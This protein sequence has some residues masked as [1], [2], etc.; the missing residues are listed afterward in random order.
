MMGFPYRMWCWY[1]GQVYVGI[2]SSW[3]YPPTDPTDMQERISGLTLLM[4]RFYSTGSRHSNVMLMC[5]SLS[6][7]ASGSFLVFSNYTFSG[8]VWDSVAWQDDTMWTHTFPSLAQCQFKFYGPSGTLENW[9]TICHLP[10]SRYYSSMFYVLTYTI[11][12]LNVLLGGNILYHAMCLNIVSCRVWNIR[13]Q[14]Q[15]D[16]NG[17]PTNKTLYRICSSMCPSYYLALTTLSDN[18]DDATMRE[19]FKRYETEECHSV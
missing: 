6:M 2:A 11:I 12:F 3:R 5:M 1:Q 14:I 7:F 18:V 19:F 13:R 15:W 8:A 16:K 17:L 9:E 10:V 4:S